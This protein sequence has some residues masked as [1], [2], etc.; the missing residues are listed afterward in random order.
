[1]PA[2]NTEK[3]DR[4]VTL[5]RKRKRGE[6]VPN[7]YETIIKCKNGQGL[8]VGVNS[9]II[10]FQGSMS[11]M[12]IVRD[13]SEKKRAENEKNL[14]IREL[15]KSKH[16]IVKDALKLSDINDKLAQHEEA[17]QQLNETKDKFFSIIAHDLKSPLSSFT[18][19][20]NIIYNEYHDLEDSDRLEFLH[21]MK[22][23][24]ENIYGLLENLLNWARSQ[25]G[26]ISYNPEMI[27]INAIIDNNFSLLEISASNK[28]ISLEKDIDDEIFVWADPSMINTVIRNLISN[29][30]KF[31][32][33]RGKII[34]SSNVRDSIANISIKDTGLG[35]DKK[36]LK[37][38]FRIDKRHSSLGTNGEKGT[39]LG[40]ILCKELIERNYGGIS[41]ESESGIG[42][43]FTFSLPLNKVSELSL[44]ADSNNGYY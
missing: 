17:L 16:M 36:D 43:S 3:I 10:P 32:P 42:S 30:L 41:V 13:I 28:S 34:V 5:H 33:E 20:T 21:A 15:E 31:T 40:L 2:K 29:A 26:A 1:M 11:F 6:Y 37:T 4:I 12:A 39:G 9:S 27:S 23:S 38:L 35:I 44:S 19:L 8:D 25:T 22:N 24:S 7:R 18:Q 14:L